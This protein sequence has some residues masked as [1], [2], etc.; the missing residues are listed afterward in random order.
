MSK[1]AELAA[2]IANV[3]KGSSLGNKN[4]ILNGAQNV[5]QRGTST[6]F[7][8]DGT[9][10]SYTTDRFQ[11]HIT[12]TDELDGTFAQVADAPSGTGLTHS[13]K[14]T[15]G[16][17]ESAVAS[18][19]A[20]WIEQKIEAQNVRELCYGTSDAKPVTLSFWVKSSI[21]G[22][23]NSSLY[24]ADGNRI[25]NKTYTISSANTWEYKTFTFEGDTGGTI[26]DDNGEGLRPVWNI[27]AGS[28]YNSTD[29]TSWGSY[30]TA[31]WAYGH[32]QNAHATTAGATFFLT[33]VQMEIGEKA[34]E[35]EHEPFETTLRKASRYY[36]KIARTDNQTCHIVCYAQT[37]QVARASFHVPMRTTP[38]ITETNFNL[39]YGSGGEE[40]ITSVDDINHDEQLVSFRLVCSA[41][42]TAGDALVLHSDGVATLTFDAEL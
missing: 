14:W 4:F 6:S 7:A 27:S 33:G 10:S 16:T 9:V 36:T 28:G 18:N 21:T 3:N 2:L 34:T 39:L 20:L 23:F 15:T 13:L 35:F 40:A 38:S 5:A 32:A 26:N 41:N 22:T 19:E 31:T 17:A 1:A 11:A 24:Q 12:N 37:A 30:S 42:L 8:H 25:L 29:R